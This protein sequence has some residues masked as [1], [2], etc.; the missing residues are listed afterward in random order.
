MWSKNEIN[1]R[2][3]D[4]NTYQKTQLAWIRFQALIYILFVLGVLLDDL[5]PTYKSTYQDYV[6]MAQEVSLPSICCTNLL[7]FFHLHT[8]WSRIYEGGSLM[9]VLTFKHFFRKMKFF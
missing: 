9:D 7:C 6:L 2:S 5:E 4:A 8:K 3:T 1:A